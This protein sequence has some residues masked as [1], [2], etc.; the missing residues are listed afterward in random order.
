MTSGGA[1]TFGS[2]TSHEFVGQGVESNGGQDRRGGQTFVQGAH[3][4]LGFAQSHEVGADNR[5]DDGDAADDQGEDHRRGVGAINGGGQ[6]HGGHHGDGVGFIEVG[7][8]TGA[9]THVVA[10]VVGDN[11]GVAG[12][13]FRNPGF[14]FTHQVGAH[15]SGFG[16]DTAAQ[17]SEHGNQGAAKAQT[18]QG[19]HGGE[20]VNLGDFGEEFVVTGHAQQAQTHDQQTGH[21]T[22][23]EGYGQGMGDAGEGSLGSPGV[24]PH[25]HIHADVTAESGEP[26]RR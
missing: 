21:R 23:L 3:D 11:G 17:T 24:G 14:Y 9:V 5:G 26:R 16:V 22:A 8:H 13:V 12:V 25:G 1:N 7:S 19:V 20:G 15:V 18:Y 2:Y 4:I 6:Q 10:H